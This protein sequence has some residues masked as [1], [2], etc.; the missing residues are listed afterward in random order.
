MTLVVRSAPPRSRA[1]RC[2][3]IPAA[4]RDTLLRSAT[5][6]LYRPYWSEMILD[7][8]GRNLA[9]FTSPEEAGRLVGTLRSVFPEASVRGFEHLIDDMTNHPKDRHVLAAA[10][11]AQARVIVT[12]NLQDYPPQALEPFGIEARPPDVF[13][14]D[15]YS[16]APD[17]MVRIVDEQAAATRWPPLSI[18]TILANLAKQ[19]APGF[20][21]RIRERLGA[22]GAEVLDE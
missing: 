7:E 13:L 15:V 20:A 10:V 16:S 4:L 19:G 11:T 1:R 14:V 8:V 3:L 22:Q 21:E 12:R 6:G 9:Q 17:A 18:G 2:V 5:K